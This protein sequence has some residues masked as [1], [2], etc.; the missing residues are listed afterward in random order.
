MR[1]RSSK[2]ILLLNKVKF[3][4]E[5]KK[6]KCCLVV[7]RSASTSRAEITLKN[8]ER[9][10]ITVPVLDVSRNFK[11]VAEHDPDLARRVAEAVVHSVGKNEGVDVSM[12]AI[13]PVILEY[14]SSS[15]IYKPSLKKGHEHWSSNPTTS[16]LHV[17]CNGNSSPLSTS[18]DGV[19][20]ANVHFNQAGQTT[21]KLLDL[22]FCSR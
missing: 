12:D 3:I 8:S 6:T 7:K 14:Y 18:C 20:S 1:K 10:P 13:A 19:M 11:I 9:N 2:S 5:L 22:E 15:N 4:S 17:L 21:L 16:W